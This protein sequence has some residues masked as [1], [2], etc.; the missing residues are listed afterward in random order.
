MTLFAAVERAA[1]EGAVT[2]QPLGP[3]TWELGGKG[4]VPLKEPF[5]EVARQ[6]C[7]EH[8]PPATV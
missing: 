1:G 4:G 6:F 5:N 2:L 7:L 3:F 8:P